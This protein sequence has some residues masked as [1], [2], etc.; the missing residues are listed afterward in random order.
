MWVFCA[1]IMN[2]ICVYY[3]EIVNNICGFLRWNCE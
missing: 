3:A 2:N 1:E